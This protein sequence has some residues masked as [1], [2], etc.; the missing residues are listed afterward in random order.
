MNAQELQS[1]RNLGNECEEAADEIER[2][3]AQQAMLMAAHEFVKQERDALRDA[4]RQAVRLLDKPQSSAGEIA[5]AALSKTPP[6]ELADETLRADAPLKALAESHK[7]RGD[8]C[9][10]L[11]RTMLAALAQPAVPQCEPVAWLAAYVNSDG[12]PDKYV[13]THHDLAVENDANRSP[14]PLFFNPPAP[15]RVPLTDEEILTAAGRLPGWL[16]HHEELDADD[17]IDFA[18]AIEAA[19]RITK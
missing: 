3:R 13:T 7:G 2:L 4:Q 11:A 9:G 18:R 16:R 5:R 1:L 17:L 12:L 6:A 15:Q 14:K 10:V 19:I 8:D